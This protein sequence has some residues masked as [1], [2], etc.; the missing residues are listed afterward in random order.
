[1]IDQLAQLGL[2]P[3]VA[4]LAGGV[5]LTI[6]EWLRAR[7]EGVRNSSIGTRLQA[8][9][10]EA[11]ALLEV[12]VVAGGG[13]PGRPLAEAAGVKDLAAAS[14]QLAATGWLRSSS[15]IEPASPTLRRRAYEALPAERRAELHGRL[16][17]ALE[18]SGED[19]VVL[20]HHAYLS[21]D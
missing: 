17:R 12:L 15:V 14:S 7:Q 4:E 13:L 3:G 16:A 11:R 19:P 2:P 5:P 21:N 20:G 6:V 9:G 1:A 18:G 8:L 10:P